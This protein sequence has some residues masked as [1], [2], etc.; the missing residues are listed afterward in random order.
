MHDNSGGWLSQ[1]AKAPKREK[2]TGDSRKIS[3]GQWGNDE[4]A[5][6]LR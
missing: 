5:Y 4:C 2:E 1:S 6:I 3:E